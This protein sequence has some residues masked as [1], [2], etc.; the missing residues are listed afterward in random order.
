MQKANVSG[1]TYAGGGL[2]GVAAQIER[3]QA[4]GQVAE[5]CMAQKGYL[6]VPKEEAEAKAAELAAVDAEKKRREEVARQTTE[7]ARRVTNKKQSAE[8]R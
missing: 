7:T 5:G 3:Q 4:V 8:A 2:A 6:L 1:V